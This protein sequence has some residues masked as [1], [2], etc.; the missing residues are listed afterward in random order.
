MAMPR[1]G[2]GAGKGRGGGAMTAEQADAANQTRRQNIY[3]TVGGLSNPGTT[4]APRP[5]PRPS[6][7]SGPPKPPTRPVSAGT[8][9]AQPTPAAPTDP[10]SGRDPLTGALLPYGKSVVPNMTTGL[11]EGMAPPS[12]ASVFGPEST[13]PSIGPIIGQ[14]VM[15]PA[16]KKARDLAAKTQGYRSW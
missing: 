4:N 15:T 3:T 9:A 12:V 13:G 11:P 7:P 5:Q 2:G 16:Q 10:L 1:T 8:P 6:G 14:T